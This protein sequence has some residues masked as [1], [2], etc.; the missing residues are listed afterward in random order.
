MR[1]MAIA[2]CLLLSEK[3]YPSEEEERLLL[4]ASWAIRKRFAFLV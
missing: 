2:A 4:I 1:K 3:L